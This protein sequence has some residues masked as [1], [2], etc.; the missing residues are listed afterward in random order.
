MQRIK[1]LTFAHTITNLIIFWVY[2]LISEFTIR[3]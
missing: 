3:I 2:K 1:F